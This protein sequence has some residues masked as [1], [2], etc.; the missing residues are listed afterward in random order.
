[1]HCKHWL[2]KVKKEKSVSFSLIHAY[3]TSDKNYIG[4]IMRRH[5]DNKIIPK[6][7]SLLLL[8]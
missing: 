8:L 6:I 5:I 3:N 4:I 1:M 2:L 7:D